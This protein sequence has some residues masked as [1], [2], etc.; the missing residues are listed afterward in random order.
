[1][2]A[3]AGSSW[4]DIKAWRKTERARLVELRAAWPSE[5]RRTWNGCITDHL[6][7]G[8]EIQTETVIGFCWP[9]KGEFDARFAVRHWRESGAMAALPEVVQNRAPLQFRQWWPAA[10]MR[11]GV[12]DI[13][14]PDGT[15]IV[16][17]DIALVPMNGFDARGYRLGYGGGFFDRTLAAVERR[18]IAIGVSYEGLRLPT[19][20]PQPH[21]VP[22]DFV[23]TEAG[24]YGAVGELLRL[25]DRA[26]SRRRLSGLLTSKRLPR[27]LFSASGYSSPACYAADFPGYWGEQN[28]KPER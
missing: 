26:E 2:T 8:F 22:M 27:A 16:T 24:I 15:D 13:P 18:M 21:D 11:P 4:E 19:I 6:V 7:N 1:M 20:Y 23:V 5:T 14:V 3:P 17:P 28:D 25:I 9:Y 12:Y 10:P